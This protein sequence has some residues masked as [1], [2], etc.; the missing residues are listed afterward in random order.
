M[1]AGRSCGSLSVAAAVAGAIMLAVDR[2][3]P[4][5]VTLAVL[6]GAAMVL[7]VGVIVARRRHPELVRLPPRPVTRVARG[8][9]TVAAVVAFGS[10]FALFMLVRDTGWTPAVVAVGGLVVTG[11]LLGLAQ[12]S[13]PADRGGGPAPGDTGAG[14]GVRQR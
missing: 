7:L 3:T 6:A 1:S 13:T 8:L 14:P 10:W 9:R 11:L 4:R 5:S 12:R 2:P